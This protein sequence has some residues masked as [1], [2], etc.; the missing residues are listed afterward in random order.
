MDKMKCC[1]KE[2]VTVF[3]NFMFVPNT[4]EQT[5]LKNKNKDIKFLS[6]GFGFEILNATVCNCPVMCLGIKNKNIV[7][8]LMNL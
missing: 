2:N 6:N 8:E 3:T 7:C 5:V 4:N 1:Y